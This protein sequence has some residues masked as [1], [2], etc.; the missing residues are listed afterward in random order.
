MSM[1]AQVAYETANTSQNIFL[2]MLPTANCIYRQFP[3]TSM[4]FKSN[5]NLAIPAMKLFGFLA[6]AEAKGCCIISQS[7]FICTF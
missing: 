5:E 2:L 1:W 4:T 3:S 6:V 7:R